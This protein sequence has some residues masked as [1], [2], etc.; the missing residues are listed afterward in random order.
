[1]LRHRVQTFPVDLEDFFRVITD[2]VDPI[3]QSQTNQAPKLACL[4]AQEGSDMK[5]L[6]RFTHFWLIGQSPYGLS[7][8]QFGDQYDT[9]YVSFPTLDEM[10]TETRRM[11]SA[12]CKDL[13]C[14]PHRRSSSIAMDQVEFLHRTVYDFLHIDSVWRNLDQRVPPHF[15]DSRILHLLNITRLKLR[16]PD[17]NAAIMSELDALAKLLIETAHPDLNERYVAAFET[18]ALWCQNFSRFDGSAICNWI[19]RPRFISNL[20]A[21]RACRLVSRYMEDFAGFGACSK[22]RL[23]IL[24][25]VKRCRWQHLARVASISSALRRSIS[26]WSSRYCKPKLWFTTFPTR[27]AA[28]QMSCS[29]C[30]GSGPSSWPRTHR[31]LVKSRIPKLRERLGN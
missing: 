23:L 31:T 30:S 4:Y 8:P 2:R 18:H 19:V 29:Y 13:L 3:Y 7:N 12:A 14:L 24:R 17:S 1:M 25:V 20:I 22:L 10:R 26:T 16:L 11:L 21:F 27:R 6:S 15:K 9:Q 5:K 28:S